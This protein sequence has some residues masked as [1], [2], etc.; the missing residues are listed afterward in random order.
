MRDGDFIEFELN[1]AL[2]SFFIHTLFLKGIFLEIF[3]EFI[4][5]FLDHFF[6]GMFVEEFLEGFFG[7]I[8]FEKFLGRFFW[9]K[10][11]WGGIFWKELFGRN[12][13]FTLLKL[14][15]YERD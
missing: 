9:E 2:K 14:F 4:W 3:G 10:F 11:F 13:L 6:A 7:R 8:F 1:K 15:E 12:Y 5:N